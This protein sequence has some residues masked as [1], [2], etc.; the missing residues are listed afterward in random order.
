MFDVG[1]EEADGEK[2]LR[3]FFLYPGP[4]TR[5]PTAYF[6]TFA[7]K[8]GCPTGS[9]KGQA[10]AVSGSAADARPAFRLAAW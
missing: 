1:Y 10:V 2:V 6:P 4:T 7:L 3:R 9:H 8:R 5:S